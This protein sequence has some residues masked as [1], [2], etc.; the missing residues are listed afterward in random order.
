L[1]DIIVAEEKSVGQNEVS[2][3]KPTKVTKKKKS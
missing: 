1:D 3:V 2:E